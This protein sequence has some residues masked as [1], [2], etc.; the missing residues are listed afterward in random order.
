[1]EKG[2]QMGRKKLENIFDLKIW[3]PVWNLRPITRET[4]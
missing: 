2:F 1:M 3:Q 4:E